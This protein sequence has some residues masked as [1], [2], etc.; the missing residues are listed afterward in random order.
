MINSA[1]VSPNSRDI[2]L[3]STGIGLS[4]LG[5]L[6]PLHS[7]IGHD[8]LINV[9]SF[10]VISLNLAGIYLSK[11]RTLTLK[12]YSL[13][14]YTWLALTILLSVQPLL[15]SIKYPDALIFPIGSLI[16]VMLASFTTSNLLNT[17]T[18]KRQFL[19]QLSIWLYVMLILTFAIQI[20][21]ALHYEIRLP[22]GLPL[23]RLSNFPNRLDGNF[24][25]PNHTGYAF[26]M[27]IC[28]VVY[29]LSLTR[30]K[31][32]QGMLLAL[33]AIF[34]VGIFFTLSRTGVL[35]V[36]LIGLVY[37]FSQAKPIKAKLSWFTGIMIAFAFCYGVLGHLVSSLIF[38]NMEGL[39]AVTRLANEGLDTQRL[40]LTKKAWLIFKDYPIQ[41]IGWRNFSIG[42]IPHVDEM[43]IVTF[44]DH[45]H[46][47][48]TQIASELGILGLLCLLPTAWLLIRACHMRHSPES[49]AAFAFVIASLA[50]ACLEYPLWYF[51]FL[52]VFA[53]FLALIE[54][55]NHVLKGDNTKLSLILGNIAGIFALISGYYMYQY[56]SHQYLFWYT[57]PNISVDSNGH[58]TLKG[59]SVFGFL[60]YNDMDL[61]SIISI[62]PEKLPQ[63]LAVFDRVLVD[64]S[65]GYNLISYG[66]FLSFDGQYAKALDMFKTACRLNENKQICGDINNALRASAQAYPQHFQTNYQSYQA[67]LKSRNLL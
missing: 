35:M 52:V 22:N 46:M 47:M 5:Y 11:F 4:I 62:T 6:I 58:K 32:L 1:T 15:S 39:S 31:R 33:F 9:V 43:P 26:A 13:S 12:D 56:W 67:W 16:L 28:L 17:V 63:K 41:G 57:H 48:F 21:Q 23:T 61:A 53:I 37:F 3:F 50:Y 49:A 42:V 27:G 30:D 40:A 25:Q 24:G 18:V 44:S 54:Q 10:I 59:K 2:T 8:F 45:S 14:I 51:R 19:N 55:K 38:S 65:S 64:E 34:S 7:P 20:M 29:Q 66:Q 36:V 60:N